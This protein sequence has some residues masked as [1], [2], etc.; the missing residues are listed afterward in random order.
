MRARQDDQLSLFNIVLEQICNPSHPLYRLAK[1]IKWSEFDTAFGK[2][3]HPTKGR[4]AIS[5]RLMVG[6]HYLKYTFNLSDEDVVAKWVE[7]PYWQYFC[8]E[9]Q[10]KHSLP[11]DP[12]SMTKWR[13]RLASNNMEK[14]LE[15]TIQ[16]GLDVGV[17]KKKSFDKVN[18][19][20][21]V[22]EKAITFPTDAKLHH[23]MRNKLV[24]VAKKCGIILRQSYTRKSKLAFLM[25]SR[26]AHARQMKRSTKERKKLKTYLG[27]VIRDI[28]RKLVH[29]GDEVKKVFSELLK[30]SHRLLTQK[31]KDKNKLYSLHA[32]EVE[33]ISKGKAHKKYE[34]GCKVGVVTTSKDN[35]VV[36]MQAFHG[37]PYDGHSLQNSMDQAERLGNFTARDVF[38]DRGYKGHD[39]DGNATVYIVGSSRKK[40]K[41][42]LRKWFKRRSAIEPVI[43][44][45][46][47]DSRLDRN[48]LLGKEG[49]KINA[50]MCGCGYNM[51]KLLKALLLWLFSVI[52]SG[53][54]KNK[55]G[56]S[57]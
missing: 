54:L 25:Q 37:N 4:P 7:N 32:P 33:C 43:G 27:R 50:I 52:F 1:T 18:V 34:F 9:Q 15:V 23:T 24:L 6:L 46:K 3:Y 53:C 39:Y 55:V 51:R 12:T 36:G 2:L 47:T 21:T 20:T 14:L 38:V 17:L 45:M 31:K 35:F 8:G 29:C 57:S 48:Y 26:Y 41:T 22:Q 44:H 5:T 11:I 13:N 56:F 30:I 42:S 49:D 16:A 10:F 40:L 19:D 28:E